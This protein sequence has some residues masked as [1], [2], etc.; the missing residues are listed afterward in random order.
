[1][2]RVK[3]YF[4]KFKFNCFHFG[5]RK[6]ESRRKCHALKISRLVGKCPVERNG[7]RLTRVPREQIQL[8]GTT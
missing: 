2:N 8:V 5:V 6:T 1:M 4:L 3:T 7:R